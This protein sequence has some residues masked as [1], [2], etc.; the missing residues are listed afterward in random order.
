ML[1]AEGAQFSLRT[2]Q[3]VVREVRFEQRDQ[4]KHAYL[5]LA[6]KQGEDAQVDF[7]EAVPSV[8]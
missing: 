5:P 2:A 8:N 6:Y 1:G 4:L 7:Y 3:Q